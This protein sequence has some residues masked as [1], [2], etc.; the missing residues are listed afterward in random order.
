LGADLKTESGC[1]CRVALKEAE[2]GRFVDGKEEEKGEVRNNRSKYR[3]QQR[4][5]RGRCPEREGRSKTQGVFT[6]TFPPNLYFY[7][8]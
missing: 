8:R 6:F 3:V 7:R 2:S 4:F 5:L 1:E